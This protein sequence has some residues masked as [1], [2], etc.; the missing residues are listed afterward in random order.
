MVLSYGNL[1]IEGG[2]DNDNALVVNGNLTIHGSYDD[3]YSGSGELIVLGNVVVDDFLNRG[4]AFVNGKL[5]LS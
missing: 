4:F 1:T 2:F 3:Y 5:D